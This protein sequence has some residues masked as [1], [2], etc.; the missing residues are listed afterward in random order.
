MKKW[1][2]RFSKMKK[3]L[4]ISNLNNSKIGNFRKALKKELI[5]MKKQPS[6]LHFIVN[7]KAFLKFY[8]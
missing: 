8:G 5:E 7:N 6:S 1:K 4:E 3:V 2:K